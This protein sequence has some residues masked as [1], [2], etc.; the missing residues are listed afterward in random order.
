MR[1]PKKPLVTVAA[2]SSLVLGAWAP[3]AAAHH[4][5]PT[6]VGV[7]AAELDFGGQTVHV[8]QQYKADGLLCHEVEAPGVPHGMSEGTWKKKGPG[9]FGYALTELFLDEQGQV[10]GRAEMRGSAILMGA[11]FNSLHSSTVYDADGTV[12]SSGTETITFSR[13][14][15]PVPP[16][17]VAPVGS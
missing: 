8:R 13:V 14:T 1:I 16:C 10:H 5:A 12:V 9:A 6:P 7:W 2:V 4:R 15:R 17:D 3:S 11:Q